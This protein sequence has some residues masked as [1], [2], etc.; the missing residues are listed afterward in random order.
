MAPATA[1]CRARRSRARATV[2]DAQCRSR[3]TRSAAEK[4]KFESRV[5][6]VI[7]TSR[8]IL[9][10]LA[11]VEI[12]AAGQLV[13]R[14]LTDPPPYDVTYNALKDI[15]DHAERG[16]PIPPIPGVPD[17]CS[18]EISPYVASTVLTLEELKPRGTDL[19]GDQLKFVLALQS[20]FR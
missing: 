18:S 11:L 13:G 8:N 10:G 15:A 7:A 9:N 5:T 12:I 2:R 16:Q 1:R 3:A 6:S 19:V 14:T 4:V 17:D 20:G